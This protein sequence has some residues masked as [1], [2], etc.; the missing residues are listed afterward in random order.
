MRLDIKPIMS[1]EE[2]IKQIKSFAYTVRA[3]I[4]EGIKDVSDPVIRQ[5]LENEAKSFSEDMMEIINELRMEVVSLPFLT[6]LFE[7]IGIMR[8]LSKYLPNEYR[9]VIDVMLYGIYSELMTLL[10][11]SVE[12]KHIY[13]KR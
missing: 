10:Y 3:T 1:L 13:R 8:Y 7:R 12:V 5:E 2:H 6:R 4:S 9:N 11:N